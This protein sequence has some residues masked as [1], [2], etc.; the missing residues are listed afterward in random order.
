[1]A[2][3]LSQLDKLLLSRLLSLEA[4]GYYTL[5]VTLGGSLLIVISPVFNVT[6]PRFSNLVA[7]GDTA[8]V[9]HL[10][11]LSAQMIAALLLPLGVTLAL[12]SR[13]VLRL[14]TGSLD[15]AEHA[16]LVTAMI[17]IG[18]T[19]NGLLYVP[20]ALRLAYG[21]TRLGLWINAVLLVVLVPTITVAAI[22]YG[23][24]GA[25]ATWLCLNVLNLALN[26]PLTH[27]RLLIGEGGRWL[28]WDFSLPLLATLAITVPARAL[29]GEPGSRLESAL[30]ILAAFATALVV[31]ALV[32]PL[33][34]ESMLRRLALGSRG[35]GAR[36]ESL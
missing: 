4:Y 5:A 12:Y 9:R 25:A 22:R 31:T 17:V 10:Y 1:M 30:H 8:A 14:W 34:R 36:T 23:A 28:V 27:R 7:Q 21:W 15:A 24:A 16:A 26:V 18:T 13:E 3:V 6:F 29:M 2:L 35:R 19:F 33:I 11:H 32:T 20:H